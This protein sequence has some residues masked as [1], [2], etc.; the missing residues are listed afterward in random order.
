MHL[1]AK[2]GVSAALALVIAA[3]ASGVSVAASKTPA[4]Q[5]QAVATA[6]DA[7][8]SNSTPAKLERDA[9]NFEAELLAINASGK[10]ET[11]LRSTVADFKTWI[12]D[13]EAT[14]KKKATQATKS[15]VQ[16]ATDTLVADEAT[17]RKDL[18]LKPNKNGF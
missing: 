4:Q 18:G 15:K 13:L 3:A 7:D 6:I 12:T 14:G 9:P 16:P 11:D 1:I 10:S 2:A 17:L 8:G 5:Y